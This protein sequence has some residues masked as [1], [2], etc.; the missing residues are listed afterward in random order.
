[1]SESRWSSYTKVSAM[2]MHLYGLWSSNVE[3]VFPSSLSAVCRLLSFLKRWNRDR[4]VNI[5]EHTFQY[6]VRKRGGQPLW[7]YGADAPTNVW[8]AG[9]QCQPQADRRAHCRLW[10]PDQQRRKVQIHG[11]VCLTFS[12][13]GCF[14]ELVEGKVLHGRKNMFLK[15]CKNLLQKPLVLV[16]FWSLRIQRDFSDQHQLLIMSLPC[17]RAGANTITQYG[18]EKEIWPV[19]GKWTG[20]EERKYGN[21]W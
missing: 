16:W 5:N 6:D 4:Q 2:N 9:E 8:S 15:C 10:R 21:D 19:S 11:D 7:E 12:P 14:P 18:I 3:L 20:R 1:M 17:S 13:T